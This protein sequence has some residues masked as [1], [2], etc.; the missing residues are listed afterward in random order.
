MWKSAFQINAAA[1][2]KQN[3]NSH[4]QQ[5]ENKKNLVT[6]SEKKQHF[7]LPKVLNKVT[8]CSCVTS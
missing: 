1:K 3:K 2:Q 6:T 7:Q 5:Q 4:I 8:F